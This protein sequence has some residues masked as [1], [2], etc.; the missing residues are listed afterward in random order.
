MDPEGKTLFVADSNNH[1]IRVLD[2]DQREVTEVRLT[3]P[4]ASSDRYSPS[5]YQYMYY[6]TDV[7]PAQ[8]RYTRVPVI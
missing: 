2:L 7:P 3:G 4:L 8:Y 1:M 6:G 5:I